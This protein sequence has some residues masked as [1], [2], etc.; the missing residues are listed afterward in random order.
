MSTAGSRASDGRQRLS[1]PQGATPRRYHA[2]PPC[3]GTRLPSLH[4][5][6]APC[7][8]ELVTEPG[9]AALGPDVGPV[10]VWTARLSGLVGR[11]VLA[12]VGAAVGTRGRPAAVM[13]SRIQSRSL[14]TR[15]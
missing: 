2:V 4:P 7:A 15:A 13:A 11:A 1:F 12:V 9:G 5:Q 10:G 8:L 3:R 6:K 14:V